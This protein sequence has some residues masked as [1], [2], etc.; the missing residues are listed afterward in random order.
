VIGMAHEHPV[1]DLHTGTVPDLAE[2][3]EEVRRTK[4][5][6]TVQIAEG[7]V[8]VVKPGKPAAQRKA[9]RQRST[10][11]SPRTVEEVFGSVPTPPHLQGKE[12]DEL[13][14]EA[15]EERAERVMRTMR[16]PSSGP[17]P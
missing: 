5:A 10:P 2:L 9:A 17:S 6:K 16:S 13:I 4:R 8:A 15:K 11:L 14:R 1:V 7:V 3:A 12:L